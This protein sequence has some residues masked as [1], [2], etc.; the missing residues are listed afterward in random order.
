ME[1]HGL[2]FSPGLKIQAQVWDSVAQ[3]VSSPSLAGSFALV[4]SFGRC[5]FWLDDR[6]VSLLLQAT[7]GGAA[8]Q[9]R[10]SQLSARVFKFFVSTSSVGLFIRRLVSFECS[11]FKLFF[12]LWG[13]GGPNWHA[14]FAAYLM[15]KRILGPLLLP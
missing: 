15:K 2:S 8:P 3:T 1:L 4:V 7:I 6:S 12:H 10:V 13:G 5:K 11:L 14:E 9:F